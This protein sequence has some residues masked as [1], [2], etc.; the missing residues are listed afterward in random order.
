MSPLDYL[1]RL[2]FKQNKDGSKTSADGEI[3]PADRMTI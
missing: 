1:F 3:F 2:K